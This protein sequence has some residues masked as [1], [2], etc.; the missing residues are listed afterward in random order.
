MRKET[1]NLYFSIPKSHWVEKILP[2]LGYQS[3]KLI[4]I[5][6]THKTLKEAYGDIIFE[7]NKAEGYFNQKDYNKCVAHCRCTLDA[8]TRNLI[9][10]RKQE[11]SETAFKW[12]KSIDTATYKWIDEL[13][14]ANTALSGKTHHAGQKRDFSRQEAESIYLVILG[15]LNFIAHIK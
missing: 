8:L 1:V 9:K 2:N 7:F 11:A 5:P 12:L 4:E 6:L 10:I 13:N 14:K 15:L 3:L